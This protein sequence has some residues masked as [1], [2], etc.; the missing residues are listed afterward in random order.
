MASEIYREP[1]LAN[2][3]PSKGERVKA[4]RA[5][6]P[7]A[8]RRDGMDDGHL[9]FIRAMPCCA[10]LKTPAGEAHHLKENTGERGMGLRSTDKWAVPLCREH[11]DEVERAGARNEGKVFHTWGID[12]PLQLAADL[13]RA[14]SDLPHMVR[15]LYGHKLIGRE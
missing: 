4:R 14:R 8:E 7:A 2:F 12:D 3:K 11:H 6:K 9:K 10:C 1:K 5:K 13:W 15:V